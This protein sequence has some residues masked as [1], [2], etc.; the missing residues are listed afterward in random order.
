M[1][2]KESVRLRPGY[3][4]MLGKVGSAHIALKL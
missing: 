2:E 4:K 3:L 1:G